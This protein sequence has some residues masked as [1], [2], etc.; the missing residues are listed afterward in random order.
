MFDEDG[1]MNIIHEYDEKSFWME[2]ID[3]LA[4]RDVRAAQPDGHL[5]PFEEYIKLAG[6]FEERYAQEFES[7]GLERLTLLPDD[8][9]RRP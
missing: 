9:Q 7:H 4:E 5:P 8:E 6:P 1:V 3:R 2:L